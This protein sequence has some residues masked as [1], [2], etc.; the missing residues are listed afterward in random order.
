M[1]WCAHS[2]HVLQGG[3]LL[4][5]W[6]HH[7]MARSKGSVSDGPVEADR[8][9]SV[10]QSLTR[11]CKSA[12]LLDYVLICSN[13]VFRSSLKYYVCAVCMPRLV[14]SPEARG[15]VVVRA[16]RVAAAVQA[17]RAQGAMDVHGR[18]P[19]VISRPTLMGI[20]V[21][22]PCHAPSPPWVV[23]SAPSGALFTHT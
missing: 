8:S 16:V 13:S 7:P 1:Q 10:A 21:T 22:Y 9:D 11:E 23:L 2:A 15:N 4:L 18:A 14:Y 19:V 6:V 20:A 3:P 5:P 17:R 12:Y